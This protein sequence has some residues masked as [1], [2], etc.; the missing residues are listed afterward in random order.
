MKPP[1]KK[2]GE[3]LWPI[4]I[5]KTAKKLKFIKVLVLSL[6]KEKNN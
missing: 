4:Y 5:C 3:P 2:Q 1:C 6:N